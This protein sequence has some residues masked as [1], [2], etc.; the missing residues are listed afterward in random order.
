MPA[1]AMNAPDAM[2]ARDAS[3]AS[4]A[5]TGTA[6]DRVAGESRLGP[7]FEPT[8]K[9]TAGPTPVAGVHAGM[10]PDAVDAL[11]ATATRAIEATMI[12]LRHFGHDRGRRCPGRWSISIHGAA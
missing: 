11:D 2:A 8:A 1:D 9:P 3:D 10:D 6:I 4:D 7:S 12:E 5:P